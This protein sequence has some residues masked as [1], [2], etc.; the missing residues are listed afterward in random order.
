M[1][2]ETMKRMMVAAALCLTAAAG[3]A[4]N[5]G[6]PVTTYWFG[7]GCPGQEQHLTDIWAKQLREGGFNTVWASCPEE[8]DIAAKH[9]L[10][11]IYSVDPTTEWAKIDLDDPAQKA[12]LTE[13]IN[14]V[15][16]HP[17]LYIYEH[18]D[19]AAAELFP[20]LARVKEYIHE[21]DPKHP[22]WHNLLPTYAN[23][24]QLGVGGKEGEEKRM[25]F[26]NDIIASYWEH[27]RLF[28]EIYRP[29]FITYDH[30][31]LKNNGDAPNY[32]LNLG[33]IRQSAS[34]RKVPFWNGLQACT[35][36]PGSLASPRS[37]RIPAVDDMR[38]LVHSTAA[39]GAHGLYYYVYCR[40]GHE[41]TIATLDGKTGE[42][43]EALK[44][45][46]REFIAFSKVLSPLDFT[47]AY[48]QGLHAPCTT[49]YGDQ[50][51]LK[52]TP[53][54]PYAELKPLQELTDTTLV[55]RFDTPGKPTHLMVVNCDYRKARTLH[56]TAPAAAERFDPLAGTWSPAGTAFDL[57]LPGG[58]GVLLRLGK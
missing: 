43:Y 3:A 45:I 48:F 31:Q 24:K 27:V 18:F 49:P 8:L 11:A 4:W 44:T 34:A 13:R 54:T 12:K 58:G 55:T 16:N 1:K 40:R 14:R 6:E 29:E 5:P 51:L 42:K 19:E 53:E 23:H 41:G 37:P 33:I 26:V 52:L 9:G 17:A 38:Y 32:F 25:G 2:N 7:P 50:A 21:L 57:A 36:R 47:G 10:R 39:Y 15:K 35:W 28:G 46:N 20:Q 22:C 56:V 30:Y